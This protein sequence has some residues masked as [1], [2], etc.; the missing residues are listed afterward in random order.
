MLSHAAGRH[1]RWIPEPGSGSRLGGKSGP[2]PMASGPWAANIAGMET[3]TQMSAPG[4]GTTGAGPGGTPPPRRLTRRLDNKMIAGVASGLADYFG[5]D[6]VLVRIGFVV[7]AAAGGAGVVAYLVA[8]WLMPAAVGPSTPAARPPALDRL[9][10]RLRDAPP[11]L[12]V[13]L[14]VLGAAAL[15]SRDQF[16]RPGL[17]W[18]VALIVLGVILFH[19]DRGQSTSDRGAGY[20]SV[21]APPVPPPPAPGVAPVPGSTLTPGSTSA[22]GWASAPGSP[23]PPPGSPPATWTLPPPARPRRE[24]SPLGW[25]T[26][27]AVLIACGVAAIL[28]TSGVTAL[29]SGRIAAIALLVV[30]LGLLVGAWVGRARWLILLGILLVP[31]VLVSS[32]IDVPVRGG[33]GDRYARPAAVEAVRPVYRLVGGRMVLDLRDVP[34]GS[35]TVPLEATVVAGRLVVVVPPQVPLEVHARVGGGEVDLF[36]ARSDGFRVDRSFQSST[37][38]GTLRLNLAVS[39]GQIVVERP[40][41]GRAG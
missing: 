22:P 37:D 30:G 14:L 24:R 2:S 1:H 25:L 6:P 10:R 18:G 34:F 23:L 29:D 7:L 13:V 40:V 39:F 20:A 38:F 17:V 15:F 16:W 12:G 19:R 31:V 36:G 35:T 32:L 21:S 9:A 5:V 28:R 3:E 41:P 8:W 4:P 33:F 26:L 27:G 11:W